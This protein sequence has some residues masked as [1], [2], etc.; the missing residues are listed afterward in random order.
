M[1]VPSIKLIRS[2]RSTVVDAIYLY[3]T[4]TPMRVIAVFLKEKFRTKNLHRRYENVQR[5]YLSTAKK[6]DF[7]SDWFTAH[8]PY[9]SW[10]FDKYG[11]QAKEEILALEIGSYEGRSSVFLL[12]TLEN[13]KLTCVDAWDCSAYRLRGRD[14]DQS[15]MEQVEGRFDKNLASFSR[16]VRKYKSTSRAYFERQSS[17]NVFDFIYVDGPH[18]C[19]DVLFDAISCF[20][21][22]KVG[23]LL[24]FDDYLWRRYK[25]PLDNPAAAINSTLRLKKGMYKVVSVYSQLVIQKTKSSLEGAAE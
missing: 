20:E 3:R 5:S 13:V 15:L 4:F 25:R 14:C 8:I 22:L 21:L 12:S 6:M 7:T 19:D 17:D 9:W 24:I 16:R 2:I 18:Y 11:L 1:A 23:G 10:L